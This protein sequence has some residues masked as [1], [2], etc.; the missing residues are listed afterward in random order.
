MAFPMTFREIAVQ[1]GI[2]TDAARFICDRA[3][4]KL[5][6]NM[7]SALYSEGQQLLRDL[8]RRS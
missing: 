8:D 2:S 1:E 7:P 6:M 4:R 5:F 3:L